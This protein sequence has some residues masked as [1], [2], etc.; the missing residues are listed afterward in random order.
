MFALFR[1][2]SNQQSQQEESDT[3]MIQPIV[4]PLPGP[5]NLPLQFRGPQVRP[6]VSQVAAAQQP[7]IRIIQ[8]AEAQ[9]PSQ[10][11]PVP[12]RGNPHGPPQPHQLP[13]HPLMQHI[14]RQI[15]AQ[16]EMAVA[17]HR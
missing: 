2:A 12:F 6:Q 14:A 15:I 7:E 9:S 4:I 3:M 11:I 17:A 8:L 13:P 5:V 10:E 16:H 1:Q